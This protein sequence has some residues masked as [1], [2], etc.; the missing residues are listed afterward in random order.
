MF[1]KIGASVGATLAAAILLQSGATHQV[2]PELASLCW[3]LIASGGAI[4]ALS[5]LFIQH[6]S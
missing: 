3:T 4:G 2:A 6:R 5:G 1:I